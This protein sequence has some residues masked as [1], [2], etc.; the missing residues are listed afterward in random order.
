VLARVDTTTPLFRLGLL[1]AALAAGVLSGINPLFGLSLAVGLVFV[2]VVM[3]DVTIGLYVFAG[4][5]FLEILPSA[6]GLTIFK[7]VGALLVLS[8]IA[9]ASTRRHL[10][11]FSVHPVLTMTLIGFLVWSAISILWSGSESAAITSL[12]R[13]ALNL[14]LFPIVWVAIY[15]REH[16]NWLIITLI[17]GTAIAAAYGI[18]S[19]PAAP[20][21]LDTADAARAT[22]TIGDA[23]QFAA[24][25][26]AG[27][28]LSLA[29]A[30]GPLTNFYVRALS[31][32]TAAMCVMAIFLTL[33]RGGL[34]ALGVSMIAA[35]FMAGRWRP[36]LTALAVAVAVGGVV[37]FT[38][39]ASVPAQQRITAIS[40]GTGRV[41]LWTVGWRMVQA[42]PING[43]GSGNFPNTSIHYL[44]RPGATQRADFIVDTPKVAHNTYLQ[45]LAELGMIGFA[46]FAGIAIFSLACMIR[47]ARTFARKGDVQLEILARGLFVG[48]IGLMTADFFISEMYSKLL[49]LLLALGPPLLLIAQHDQTRAAA[50][51]ELGT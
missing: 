47:A 10:G 43:I 18:V 29:M 7:V 30:V 25:L 36:L 15:K 48:L 22:G 45:V 13:Y 8:T 16:V 38:T 50:R 33:S 46:M 42:H 49:W 35:V 20:G 2:G 28:A 44:L 40:G 24:V 21:A 23:N 32:G 19:P 31:L 6:G 5:S 27:L 41:D 26:V 11:L 14:A 34:V 3:A 4:L 12:Q 37:Y 17:A 39:F 9:A 1:G 51:P